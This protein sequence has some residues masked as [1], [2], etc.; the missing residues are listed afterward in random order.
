MFSGRLF[1]ISLL[2][3]NSINYNT[4]DRNLFIYPLKMPMALSSNFA[5][6]RKDHFH[7]GLDIKTGGVTGKEVLAA[8][9]GYIYR[10]TVSPA[11]FGKAIFIRHPNGYSTVYGH[12]ERFAPAIDEYVKERQY[13]NKSFLISLYPAKGEFPVKQGDVIAFSGN[14]GNSEGPH[15]HWEIRKSDSE[16]PVNPLLF[17]PC[18]SDNIKPL[19]EKLAVYP[20][21]RGSLVNR[22]NAVL[23][24][25]L[26]AGNGRYSLPPDFHISVSGLTGFGIESFDQMNDSQNRYGLYSMELSVD[27]KI[28]Y[29]FEANSFPFDESR[30]VNSHIDYEAYMRENIFYQHAFSLPNEKLSMCRDEVNRGLF[31]FTD[32]L[33]H[34]VVITVSDINRNKSTLT[35]RVKSVARGKNTGLPQK[36]AAPEKTDLMPFNRTNKFK[37]SDFSVTIPEGALYDTLRFRYRVLPRTAGMLSEMHCVHDRFTPLHKACTIAIK[38]QAVPKGKESKMLLALSEPDKS[39]VPVTAAWSDGYLTADVMN[40]GNYYA[41]IDT[42]PPRITLVSLLKDNNFTGREYLRLRITDDF[43]G[44]KS[45]VPEIDGN[46]ALFEYDQKTGLLVY[47]F[48]DKKITRGTKHSLELSVSDNQDNTSHYRFSFRW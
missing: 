25:K 18:N 42:I 23:K 10:I 15:L 20:E 41:A 27:G 4:G 33:E 14:T 2:L 7:S 3:F 30:Y 11:G 45:Y 36:P 12:L 48:D 5:E 46:W 1:I 47:K 9:D 40:F 35:F 43:S 32:N 31:N 24:T 38:P 39:R 44:I 37:T 28:I 22:S 6:L 34:T 26:A 17:I 21:G 13:E 8:A 19:I 16:T 29:R